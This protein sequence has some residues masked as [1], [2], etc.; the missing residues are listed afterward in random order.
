[1]ITIF[2]IWWYVI[3]AALYTHVNTSTLFYKT[4]LR[5]LVVILKLKCSKETKQTNV[6]QN[7]CYPRSIEIFAAARIYVSIITINI[8][9]IANPTPATCPKT[10][11]LWTHRSL[12]H[13]DSK[14]QVRELMLTG[15]LQH[16]QHPVM[17][18]SL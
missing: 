4:G 7:D 8:W 12:L 16:F 9:V 3:P 14:M 17:I 5:C 13:L 18:E 11:R 1:M 15:V 10:L 2:Q 6:Q